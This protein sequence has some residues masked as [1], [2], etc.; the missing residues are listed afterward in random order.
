MKVKGLFSK[1]QTIG[2]INEVQLGL[3]STSTSEVVSLVSPVDTKQVQ[4]AVWYRTASVR[5][6]TEWYDIV[7]F[8]LLGHFSVSL[9]FLDLFWNGPLDFFFRTHVNATPLCT[10]SW[11]GPKW[12]GTISYPFE[13]GLGHGH[14]TIL[15]NY[16]NKYW[17]RST[18]ICPKS[19]Q[20]IVKDYIEITTTFLA[21]YNKSQIII[22]WLAYY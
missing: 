4:K 20:L 9:K 15:I 1:D 13:Q 7:S 19:Y 5:T 18:G 21:F 22:F 11:N 12:N 3:I 8:W 17:R 16:W 6:R 10:T 2:K 14:M